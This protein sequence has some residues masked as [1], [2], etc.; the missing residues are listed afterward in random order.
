MRKLTNEQEYS[1][2]TTMLYGRK[3]LRTKDPHVLIYLEGLTRDFG[4]GRL[5]YAKHQEIY[6]WVYANT[7]NC[8]YFVALSD[9]KDP[10][11]FVLPLEVIYRKPDVLE[12]SDSRMI[13][14]YPG[15]VVTLSYQD[16]IERIEHEDGKVIY[17]RA[18][19]EVQP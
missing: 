15:T 9:C 7:Y 1:D 6:V 3:G 18:A 14:L 17:D 19:E 12:L 8:S 13:S 10:D 5:D 16:G 2:Y 4:A 11:K